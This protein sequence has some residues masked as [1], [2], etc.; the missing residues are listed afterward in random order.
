VR[1]VFAP[2]L[3][4]MTATPH[5]PPPYAANPAPGADPRMVGMPAETISRMHAAARAIRDQA[6]DRADSLLTDVLRQCPEHPEALRLS[7]ILR[8]NQRRPGDA[9]ALL[10]VALTHWPEDAL[11]HSDM[12]SALIATGDRADAIASRERAC[13]LA[14]QQGMFWF[15]LGRLL[16]LQGTTDRAIDA[17]RKALALTPDFLPA[18]ILLADALVHRGELDEAAKE[19]R[20]AIAQYPACGDAWRGLGNIKTRPLDAEDRQTLSRQLQRNDVPEADWIAM[21]YAL[22]KAEEDAQRYPQAFEILSAANVR[23]RRKAPWSADAL[24]SFVDAS[25]RL[26]ATLPVPIDPKLGHEAILIVGLPRSGSTLIEQ[27]LSA[28][29]EVEGASELPELNE[30]VQIESM[31]RKQPYPD[32]IRSASATDWH[33]LGKEYLAR[34]AHWRQKRPRFTDKMPENWKHVGILRAMLPGATVIDVR[35]DPIETGWSCFK[36]QFYQLPHFSCSLSDIGVYI[37][38]CEHAMDVWRQRDPQRIRLQRYEAL[39]ADFETEVRSLLAAC[40]LTFEPACLDYA[41]SSRSVRTASAAQVRQPLRGDTSRAHHYDTLLDPL[42]RSL[43][44]TAFA[45]SH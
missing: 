22:G 14:P 13:E 17:L 15:N 32:W 36:Q 19:Y 30:I 10:R 38:A 11:L 5:Y 21:A 37:Q 27:I 41:N 45:P 7:A 26:T 1:Y 35:R 18:R 12:A 6:L 39:L 3:S 29:S 42:R 2:R 40:D 33:R 25:L 43:Q 16:Q 44:T 4:D 20:A 24:R 9:A 23:M 34:T 31:R 28:H 8:L